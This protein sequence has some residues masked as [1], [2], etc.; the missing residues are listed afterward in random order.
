MNQLRLILC[1]VYVCVLLNQKLK[2][3]IY[4]LHN[5]DLKFTRFYH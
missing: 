3:Y 5:K 2:I 1:I 4:A